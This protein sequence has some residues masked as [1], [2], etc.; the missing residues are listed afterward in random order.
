M[1]RLWTAACLF[2]VASTVHA[3]AIESVTLLSDDGGEPGTEVGTFAP[4]NR[5]QHFSV[6]LDE[7]KVGSHDF[8][9]E[10]WVDETADT[11]NQ[12]LTQVTTSALLANT[13]TAQVSLPNDWPTGWYRLDVKMDGK[14]IGSH[15]YV[16]SKAWAEQAIVSWTPYRD[17]GKGAAGS[18]VEALS[19]GDQVLHFE[20]QSNGYLMRGAKLKIIYTALETSAGNNIEVQTIDYVVPDNDS[21][22]NILTSYVSLPRDWPTGTYE[23]AVLEG[24]RVLGKHRY[25]VR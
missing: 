15:R 10:F 14:P 21:I 1:N 2:A 9:I 22:F 19:A 20:M 11:K 5:I 17:D 12:K 23:I 6:K 16:V 25:E 8:V 3:V 4:D 24:R 13:I 7:M 18:A